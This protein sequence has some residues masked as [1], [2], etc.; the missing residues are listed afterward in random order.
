MIQPE[1]VHSRA[2]ERVITTLIF[3]L[4]LGLSLGCASRSVLPK[5]DEVKISR[6]PA[7]EKCLEIGSVRGTTATMK[8]SAEQALEDLKKSAAAKGANYVSI[9]Q[10]SDNQTMVTGLAY[11]CP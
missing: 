2:F 10:Y 11:E 1:T 5:T 7:P 9:K 4:P 6:E 3:M 8:G